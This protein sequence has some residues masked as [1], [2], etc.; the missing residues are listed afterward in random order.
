MVTVA[1]RAPRVA[2]ARVAR[3]HRAR[4]SRA[5]RR[6]SIQSAPIARRN[7][8]DARATPRRATRVATPRR[9]SRVGVARVDGGVDGALCDRRARRARRRSIAASIDRARSKLAMRVDA[10]T[11]DRSRAG[12]GKSTPRRDRHIATTRARARDGH[13]VADGAH[14]RWAI[15]RTCDGARCARERRARATQTRPIARTARDGGWD[16]RATRR[17]AVRG[18]ARDAWERARD[19]GWV[20]MPRVARDGRDGRGRDEDDARRR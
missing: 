20:I 10:A 17:R 13:G 6:A 15:N 16:A 2:A 14:A 8:R 9:A 4:R 19:D 12:R 11:R 18:R 1:R 5:R 3:R 7:R